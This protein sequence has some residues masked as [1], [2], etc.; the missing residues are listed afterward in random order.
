MSWLSGSAAKLRHLL[1]PRSSSLDFDEELQAHLELLAERFARQGMTHREA[2]NAARR[3]FGNPTSLKETRTQMQTFRWLETLIRDVRFSLRSLGRNPAFA[4]AALVTLALG[5]AANS[6]IFSMVSRFVL[7]P[8][9]VS[10]PD[11]LM[12]LHTTHDGECCNAFTW[13]LFS[14]LREQAKSFSGVAAYYDLI[15]ASVGGKGDP[16]RV[17]GQAA[18]ANF[19]D[20]AQLRMTLGRGFSN[21]EE[22]APVVVISH[23][24]WQ[25]RFDADPKILGKAMLLSGRPFTVVGVAPPAFHGVDLI[26]DCQFWVPLG[27]LDQLLP[28]TSNYESRDYHWLAPIGRLK[29]GVTPARAAV[30]LDLIARLLA[31]AHPATDKN[32]GFRFERAGSLPPRDA[33]TA[34]MFFAA[35]SVVVL[36]VLCIACANVANLLLAQAAG[37]QREMAMRLALGATRGQLCLGS[38]SDP[39]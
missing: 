36:L 39:G 16:E 20:V 21:D 37:R 15:P 9:P 32:Q 24:L 28:K 7:H 29:D 31:K 23:R 18:T 27:E 14:D 22:R 25:N 6:T 35:L 10:N 3:Q 1:A 12:A 2:W 5:I 34:K 17:L 33:G 19:F 11:A 26:L 8:P 13:P 4:C 30:E 38:V